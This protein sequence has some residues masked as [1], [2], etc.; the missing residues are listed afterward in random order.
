ML[1]Q[2]QLAAIAAA[3]SILQQ[4][5]QQQQ[6]LI[7]QYQ[8]ELQQIQ[9]HLPDHQTTN[10]LHHH[11]QPEGDTLTNKIPN[12]SL[13]TAAI[14]STRLQHPSTA[15]SIP[16]MQLPHL[17]QQQLSSQLAPKIV[18]YQQSQSSLNQ[19]ATVPASVTVSTT[20]TKQTKPPISYSA[21]VA[22]STGPTTNNNNNASMSIDRNNISGA[23]GINN[24]NVT[25]PASQS[26]LH[27]VT[28]SSNGNDIVNHLACGNINR[29]P[30]GFATISNSCNNSFGLSINGHHQQMSSGLNQNN[31]LAHNYSVGVTVPSSKSIHSAVIE[32]DLVTRF[33]NLNNG[34]NNQ[35]TNPT[36]RAT[37]NPISAPNNLVRSSINDHIQASTS[38]SIVDDHGDIFSSN[39][40][41]TNQT[42]NLTGSSLGRTNGSSL[43]NQHNTNITSTN[44][45]LL[46]H[47]NLALEPTLNYTTEHSISS[48]AH[49]IFTNSINNHNQQH[50]QQQPTEQQ[51]NSFLG[52]HQTV[53]A[54]TS[55]DH[56][57]HQ[58]HSANGSNYIVAS[59]SH[60]ASTSIKNVPSHS[61]ATNLLGF[62]GLYVGNL[63]PDLTK[64]QLEKIFSKYGEPVKAHRLIRSPV[65][66]I[67]YENTESPRAAI[68]D[69][70]GVL[71]PELTL[72]Q[73]QA[74]KLHF[75]RN[76]SQLKAN[77]RPTELPKDD[78]G[79]C[80]GWRTTVCRRGKS[81]PK[82]HISINRGIDFQMWMIKSTPTSTSN[83][84]ASNE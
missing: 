16:Q 69:L 1:N 79:E 12:D 81:C 8:A 13:I 35:H 7:N 19:Q 53:S 29:V 77:Y 74:L 50:Q 25:I 26:N 18:D 22:K 71:L 58:N 48:P 73:D 56:Q 15:T 83:T 61:R 84:F 38:K 28:N 30:S 52:R 70:Y 59:I 47:P 6:A 82:K 11:H 72:N 36:Y 4:Q 27:S 62:M 68:D 3:M 23:N 10:Q 24:G 75:D 42:N 65:A 55:E 5:Q 80:Y 39:N 32:S 51:R 46:Q 14:Q 63:S 76:D 33:S 40:N 43:L 2:E 21:I 44:N 67:K 37:I 60:P 9:N 45:N 20:S 78:N 17:Q 41:Y 64:E 34:T 31:T 66:F 54:D 49:Q 57:Q